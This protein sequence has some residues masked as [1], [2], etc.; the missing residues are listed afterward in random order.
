MPKF[1]KKTGPPLS[2]LAWPIAKHVEQFTV[3]SYAAV[4][5]SDDLFCLQLCNNTWVLQGS[6]STG[7]QYNWSVLSTAV[8]WKNSTATSIVIFIQQHSRQFYKFKTMQRSRQWIDM[9]NNQQKSNY[10][11]VLLATGIHLILVLRSVR[12]ML[13]RFFFGGGCRNCWLQNVKG[14]ERGGY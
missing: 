3:D 12:K 10:F 7:E 14:R 2:F 4:T 5:A 6:V 8:C 13:T 1:V 11:F 9:C